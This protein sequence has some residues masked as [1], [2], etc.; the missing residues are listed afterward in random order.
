MSEKTFRHLI[1]TCYD[2]LL[3]HLQERKVNG[4]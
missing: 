2:K 1:N 4:H 3:N